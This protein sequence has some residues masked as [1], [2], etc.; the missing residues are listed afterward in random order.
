MKR[1]QL[2]LL[3]IFSLI[4]FMCPSI[5]TLA[6][7][8]AYLNKYDFL[9][10]DLD[11][12]EPEYYTLTS[13]EE[14]KIIVKKYSMDSVLR[15]EKH[16]LN[17]NLPSNL[18]VDNVQFKEQIL[19]LTEY[20]KEGNL[21]HYQKMIGPNKIFDQVFYDN[22]KIKYQKIILDDV[23]VDE[24]YYE[25]DG[26]PRD[27]IV[28]KKAEPLGG[29][30][31][32]QTFLSQNLKYPKQARNNREEGVAWLYFKINEDGKMS[33]LDLMNPE[34]VSPILAK[35]ALRVLGAYPHNWVPATYDGKPISS[36]MKLPLRFK[37]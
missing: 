4:L 29:V 23:I 9:I 21:C 8:V 22:K 2:L 6:Q 20:N 36:E 16:T 17:L 11:L 13:I 34:D 25:E 35:E 32:W 7:Q 30:K 12:Y 33:D 37:I 31:G 24:T 1:S 15:S 28:E 18:N 26:T 14:N 27:I 10:K 3:S 19:F 5:D